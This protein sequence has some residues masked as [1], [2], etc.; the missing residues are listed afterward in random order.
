MTTAV[1]YFLIILLRM[2]H[3]SFIKSTTR[4]K[5]GASTA[6][7]HSPKGLPS[8]HNPSIT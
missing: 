4:G 3:L 7:L 1:N 5:I 2:L 6:L 8:S